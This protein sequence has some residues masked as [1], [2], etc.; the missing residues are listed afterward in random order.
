M[1]QTFY[2]VACFEKYLAGECLSGSLSAIEVTRFYGRKWRIQVSLEGRHMIRHELTTADGANFNG[3]T[4]RHNI[5]SR[6][7][8][9]R[10]QAYS[11]QPRI[12]LLCL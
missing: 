8:S 1:F 2:T 9:A 11:L 10:V 3:V 12:E 5:E 6:D 7:M 4:E